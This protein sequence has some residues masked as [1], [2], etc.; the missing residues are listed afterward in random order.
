MSNP[1]LHDRKVFVIVKARI[2]HAA[3]I[4]D[5]RVIEERAVI[6][7]QPTEEQ[8]IAVDSRPSSQI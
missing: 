5:D 2:T 4:Q 8:E 7:F 6:S 3:A 1:S